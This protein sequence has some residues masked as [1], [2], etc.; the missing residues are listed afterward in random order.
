MPK[1]RETCG[2]RDRARE[3]FDGF[4]AAASKRESSCHLHG[5]RSEQKVA[6]DGL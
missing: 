4:A 5:V 6:Q 2:L 1:M 3:G